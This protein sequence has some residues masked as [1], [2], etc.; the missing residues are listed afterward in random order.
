MLDVRPELVRAGERE[1]L[2][3]ELDRSL[4]PAGEAELI[5]GLP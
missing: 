2:V 5:R 1:R 3:Q 4:G